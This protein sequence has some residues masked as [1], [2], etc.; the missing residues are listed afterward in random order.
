MAVHDDGVEF[1]TG[2]FDAL[3]KD[4]VSKHGEL[5][6]RLAV[7]DGLDTARAAY[8]AARIE[9]EARTVD[10]G[11]FLWDAAQ[12]HYDESAHKLVAALEADHKRLSNDRELLLRY[13]RAM[14]ADMTKEG[15]STISMRQMTAMLDR[16]A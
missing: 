5:L 7:D 8:E 1:I 3:I 15:L 12:Q 10:M 6:K 9:V 11:E 4:A 13:G 14:L 2:D 16:E